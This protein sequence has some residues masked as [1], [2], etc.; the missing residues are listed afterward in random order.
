[1]SFEK[2]GDG[3]LDYMP[4]RLSSSRLAFRG[5]QPDLSGKY[6][7]FLGG[8]ETYGKFVPKPYPQRIAD[9]TGRQCAN[10]GVVNAGID[11]FLHTP[12][13]LQAAHQAEMTVIQIM[14]AHNMSN[15]YYSVHPRRNDRFTGASSTMQMTFREL[16]F[17]EFHFTR[18]MVGALAARAPDR[19]AAMIE[20][21]R[22]AWVARMKLLIATIDAPVTLLWFADHAPTGNCTQ[23]GVGRDP[24]FVER[25]MLDLLRPMV[26]G[27]VEAVV[28][29]EALSQGV[30]GMVLRDLERPAAMRMLGC[31]AHDEAANALL[32]M[33][34]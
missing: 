20:E 31:Q 14:G 21:L 34:A 19:Y 27:L 6:T 10:F 32:S 2:V 9:M 30:R 24:L 22:K 18:H 23:R 28:S 26:S 5:P 17:T 8:T 13:V 3:A 25:E 33:L 1:M 4:Y 11:V 12:A 7:V 16:D 15:R 29:P